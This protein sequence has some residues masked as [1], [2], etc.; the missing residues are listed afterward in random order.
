MGKKV[1]MFFTFWGLNVIKKQEKPRVKKE[2]TVSMLNKLMPTS[3]KKLK[4]SNMNMGGIGS[5]MMRQRMKDKNVDALERMIDKAAEMGVNMIACQMSM[6]IMGVTK[7]ELLDNV[8]IGGVANYL[9]E[10]EQSNVNLFV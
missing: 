8:N 4:L 3:A 9:E 7:A 10:A 1:T 5:K 2:F 6:D